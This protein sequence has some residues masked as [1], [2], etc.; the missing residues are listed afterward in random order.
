M[1]KTVEDLSKTKK[2]LRIEIPADS[3]EREIQESLE[4]V[5]LQSRLP[6]FRPGKTPMDLIEKKFGKKVEA[7]VLEKVLPRVYMAALREANISPVT[8][9]VL[10]EEIN[11]TR[12]QPVSMSLTV[13]IMP[14][15][16]N[17]NY[18]QLK[19]K[20]IPVT[21]DETD[22]KSVLDRLRDERAAYEPS[23]EPAG[24]DDMVVIDYSTVEGDFEAKDFM[25]K[26]GE[27]MFPA[28]FSKKLIGKNKGEKFGVE[29]VFPANHM[30]RKLA[31]RK[32]KLNV[33]VSDIKKK[34]SPGLDD[35]FA[36][37]IKFE[38]LE[39]LKKHIRDSV[40]QSKELEA[41]KIHKAE[42]LKKLIASCDF[43]APASLVDRELENLISKATII[44]S[45]SAS[46]SGE[47]RDGESFKPELKDEAVRN[48]K[49]ALL[50]E[51]IG[52][53]EN[54]A[55][56]EED[57]KTAIISMSQNFS[58]SPDELMKFYLSKD[59]SLQRLKNSIFEDKV[60]DLLL[61][62]AV[63]EKGAD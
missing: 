42:L 60:M 41:A 25:V 19:V 3:I 18:D 63:K 26:V 22:V 9:P 36:K 55:V 48:V 32:V 49:A 46:G 13:E 39:A 62:K 29:T 5:R 56:S 14:E 58:I 34:N 21:V 23:G 7:E 47:E 40:L 33:T 20:D 16:A 30:N 4:K 50:I 6:G 43:E 11:F 2:R 17:L 38:N 15:I 57:L 45:G 28:D 52:K 51:T 10:D 54:V 59:G 27:N 35:E 24:P 8:N 44:T 1:L 37:D 53:K 12:R 31:G 61:S